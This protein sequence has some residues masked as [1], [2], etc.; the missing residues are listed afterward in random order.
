MGKYGIAL[1]ASIA[2]IS[3]AGCAPHEQTHAA[4]R[5]TET[6]VRPSHLPGDLV[7][8]W[9]GS[10]WPVAASAGGDN[11]VG[12]LIIT[13][14]DDGTYTATDQRR[15]TTRSDTGVV[16]ANGRTVTLRSSSGGSYPF[17][18]RGDT[19]YGLTPDRVTGYVLGVSLE[20]GGD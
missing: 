6:D 19:L 2:L 10:F 11:A 16:I 1:L 7:G 15:G 5:V 12:N 17:R 18:H 20:K 13:I 9:R 14:K 8:T 4:V 3:L